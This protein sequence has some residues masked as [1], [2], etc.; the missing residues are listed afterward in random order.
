MKKSG[1]QVYH[2]FFLLQFF[3]FS[4]TPFLQ[5]QKFSFFLSKFQNSNFA[6]SLCSP[7]FFFFYGSDFRPPNSTFAARTFIH[8]SNKFFSSLSFS[9]LFLQFLWDTCLFFMHF[10]IL[11][12]KE[13]EFREIQPRE[14]V[15]GL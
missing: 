15:N 4:T 6:F 7:I 9:S 3:S 10:W 1:E 12:R 8:N 2:L 14:T 13:K 11:K 5:I